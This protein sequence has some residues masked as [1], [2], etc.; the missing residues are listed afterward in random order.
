MAVAQ[1]TQPLAATA[2]SW[3]L[4]EQKPLFTRIVRPWLQ[5]PAGLLGLFIASIFI[6]VGLTEFVVQQSN[7]CIPRVVCVSNPAHRDYLAPLDPNGNDVHARYEAPSRAHPF[8][9]D[10]FGKDVFSRILDGSGRSFTFG[11]IILIVGFLPGTA[12]GIISGYAGRWIDY[13]IQRSA[14]AWTAFPQLP[15]LLTVRAAVGPGLTAVVI[16]IALGALFSGSRILR[17]VA[18]IEKHKDYILSARSLGASETHVLI[19]HILPNIMPYILVGVS[20]VFAVAILAESALSFLGLLGQTGTP[21]W[22]ADLARGLK[23]GTEYPH[24]VIFPGL[25]ISLVILAF[26]L[27]GDTLRDIL[28]PRLRGSQATGKH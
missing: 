11:I 4:P 24:L 16:V 8:G 26:N 28:D 20:S 2:E 7:V 21:R 22:G 18:L 27:M 1:R 25:V 6:V 13:A 19:R 10:K 23:E 9:T 17:A 12:L 3:M 15:I 5:N 14:E